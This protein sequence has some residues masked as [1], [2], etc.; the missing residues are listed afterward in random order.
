MTQTFGTNFNYDAIQE[1]SFQTGGY[2]AEFGQATGGIINLV[3]K[4][5]GNDFSGSLDIRYRDQ[6]FSENGDYFD[7]DAQESSFE[8]YS[9]TLGGPILRDK[10]WFFISYE[11][12][13]TK[14]QKRRC[15]IRARI[16]RPEL[17]RQGD[18]GRLPT[19]TE[20]FSA[21]QAILRT[22]RAANSSQFVEPAASYTQEQGG[23]IYGVEL[24]S[25]LSESL[26]LNLKAGINRGNL[27]RWAHQRHQG[28]VGSLQPGHDDHPE[29][30][31]GHL[32]RGP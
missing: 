32:H 11:Y 12:V 15:T 2:E 14:A 7:K 25:V 6:D 9:M 5:G 4:S 13:N 22:S 17:Y 18:P 3:T 31:L 21:S 16:R 28:R 23:S 20:R 1:V 24:N 27:G 30:L 29:Q 26:L 10:L 19:A 8:D